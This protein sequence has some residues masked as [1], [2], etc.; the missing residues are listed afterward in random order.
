MMAGNNGTALKP[1]RFQLPTAAPNG[2]RCPFQSRA[3]SAMDNTFFLNPNRSSPG[4]AG[5]AEKV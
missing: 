5:E 1:L 2:D 3:P 4:S